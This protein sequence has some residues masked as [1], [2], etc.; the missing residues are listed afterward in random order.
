MLL[1]A[2]FIPLPL[3]GR[4]WAFLGESI[5]KFPLGVKNS[6]AVLS[7]TGFSLGFPHYPVLQKNLY[8]PPTCPH[9]FAPK[10]NEFVNFHAVFG[11]FVPNVPPLV[12]L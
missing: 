1:H 10:N 5:N 12:T 4:A 3:A 6:E 9:C 2:N 11:H 7:K 8:V